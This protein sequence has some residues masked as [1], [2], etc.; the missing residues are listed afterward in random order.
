LGE[1]RTASNVPLLLA[2]QV[3]KV[4]DE[5]S[6]AA[7][8]FWDPALGAPS[9][10]TAAALLERPGDIWHA[11]LK[12]GTGGMPSIIDYI[13]PTWMLNR[14]PSLDIEATSWRVSLRACLVRSEVL[15]QMGFLRLDFL[16][17]GAAALEWGHRCITRG[18]VMRHLPGLVP[19]G[20]TPETVCLPLEDEFRFALYRFGRKWLG[21]AAMRMAMS[22]TAS[23][24]GTVRIW[25]S[26]RSSEV[27]AEPE[28][29]TRPVIPAHPDSVPTNEPNQERSDGLDQLSEPQKVSVLVPTL[30]RYPLLKTVLT[31]LRGQTV[32]PFEIIVVD[33]SPVAQLPPGFYDEFRD[34]PLMV[35]FRER[36]GQCTSRNAGLRAATGDFVLFVDDDDEVPDDLVEAH[37]AHLMLNRLD[38]SSGVADEPGAGPLPHNFTYPRLS[39]VFPTNN[40]LMRK[41]VLEKSGLFDLAYDRGPRADGDLG[42]RVYLAGAVMMLDPAIRVLHHHAGGG[43]RTHKARVVTYASSRQRILVRQ[44]LSVTEFYLAHRYFSPRQIREQTWLCVLGTFSLHG[45]TWR[46]LLKALLS[47][48]LLPDTCLRL[49]ARHRRA[50]ALLTQYPQVP[51][52]AD[53]QSND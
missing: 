12:L 11:G 2:K 30:S 31:Q 38:V 20:V 42:M 23:P 48:P 4:V 17:L 1:V 52:L 45:A 26:L 6:A 51:S 21:W 27:P 34:L 43:L 15:R 9:E 46:R 36:A 10:E 5:L 8:L 18:V 40:T 3:G 44:L 19:Q 47:L 49:Q 24:A 37:L 25:A 13:H 28:P 41:P 32:R 22:G 29:F 16:T 39:D 50:L 35:L 53:G 33:Q 7:W 14:D